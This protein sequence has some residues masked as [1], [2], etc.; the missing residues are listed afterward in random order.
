MDQSHELFSLQ[1]SWLETRDV[2]YLGLMLDPGLLPLI[3]KRSLLH[4]LYRFTDEDLYDLTLD[5]CIRL[6]SNLQGGFIVHTSWYEVSKYT[7]RNTI[8]S[9]LTIK[10][11]TVSYEEGKKYV[12]K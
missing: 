6:I 3:M 2:K 10:K 4:Y 8:R 9:S 7:A 11:R 12:E 1:D 5:A